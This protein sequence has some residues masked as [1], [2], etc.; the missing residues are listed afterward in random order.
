MSI[1][2]VVDGIEITVSNTE[3]AATLLKELRQKQPEKQAPNEFSA[4][5]GQRKQ[6][7]GKAQQQKHRRSPAPRTGVPEWAPESALQFLLAIRD[8]G[9]SGTEVEALMHALRVTKPKA[10]G[11]RSAIINRLLNQMGFDPGLVYDNKR[12]ANGRIWKPKRAI[13]EA[14]A[15][16]ERKSAA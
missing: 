3:E 1:K 15:A 12:T 8:G 2:M 4:E 14:I 7:K 5:V 10:I 6:P 9:N 16:L 11:G 13:S